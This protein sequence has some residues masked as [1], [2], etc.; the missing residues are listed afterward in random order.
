MTQSFA[1][2]DMQRVNDALTRYRDPVIEGMR[3]A[4]DRPEIQHM[5]HMRYHLGFEDAEGRAIEATGGKMLR[6]AVT[7]LAC[8]AVGAVHRLADEADP[9][10]DPAVAA[11]LRLSRIHTEH[12]KKELD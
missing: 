4:L 5:R 12:E 3:A 2:P 11:V 6:P 7:L 1:P 8:E 10:T 9:T